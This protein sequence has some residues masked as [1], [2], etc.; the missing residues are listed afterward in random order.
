[1]ISD[2]ATL[3]EVSIEDAKALLK[4]LIPLNNSFH[5][6]VYFH[7]QITLNVAKDDAILELLA[8]ANFGGLF[9]GV[10]TPNIESLIET[11]KPQNYRLD[12]IEAVK[13]IQSYGLP[14]QA[15]MVVGFDHDDTSIFQ[16]QVEFLQETCIPNPVLNILYA[17]IGTKLWVRLHKEGR[18]VDF[19]SRRYFSAAEAHKHVAD[20]FCL[21][22]TNIIPKLMTWAEL[23]SGYRELV[24]QVRDWGNFEARV[25]GMVSRMARPPRVTRRRSRKQ[26]LGFLKFALFSMDKE[27]RRVTFRL[28]R[29]TFRRAP[30]MMQR[31]A[32]LI[33]YQ[34]VEARRLPF[35]LQ[36]LDE[37]IR[38]EGTQPYQLE[39]TIFFV[40]EA[41]K[42]PYKDM[43]PALYERVHQGLSDKSRA[44]DAMVEVTY[45]FLTRWGPNFEQFEEQHRAFLIEICD[46]TIAK[47]NGTMPAGAGEQVKPGEAPDRMAGLSG[48]QTLVWLRRLAEE[49]LH[50]VEQDLRSFRAQ[51]P[52][53]TSS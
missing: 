37:E 33:L 30:F 5:R 22:R 45:D 41:F 36:S 49:V 20:T 43:F 21:A 40:P 32:S 44:Q 10:E 52:A 51:P 27:A 3:T 8:D 23:L 25:K 11:N 15:G 7:T 35:Q 48:G 26:T 14:I 16:R 31:V 34:Y 53:P 39:Q 9:I 6:P 29:H 28:L 2:G 50:T 4:E 19:S 47:E 38:L 17:P 24:K 18:I 1:L 13:K 12:V 42:K 46:R